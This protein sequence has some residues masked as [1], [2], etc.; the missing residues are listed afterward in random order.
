MSNVHQLYLFRHGL[1]ENEHPDHPGVDFERRLTERGIERTRQALAGAARLGVTPDAIW[2]SPYVRTLQTAALAHELLPGAA[3]I[4]VVDELA[5]EGSNDALLLRLASSD[6]RCLLLIGHEPNLSDLV[7]AVTS[8]RS[9]VR[10]RFKKAGLAHIE[11]HSLQ[12]RVVGRL[13]AYLPP[14][15]LRLVGGAAE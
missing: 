3:P 12:R 2:T 14:R 4:V 8:G 7:S 13:V 10:Q 15:V 6:A 5:C 1:A 11:L 9:L